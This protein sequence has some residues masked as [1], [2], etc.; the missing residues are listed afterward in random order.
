MPI[1]LTY[2]ELTETLPRIV[3]FG[4]GGAGGNAVN[5]M[6]ESE[7]QGVEFVA[8]NT[9]AQALNKSR[10]SKQ[11][12]LGAGLT[13]GLGAGAQP[14]VG[15]QAAEEA[16]P[17]LM[18]HLEGAHMCF[19]T[20]GMGGG[21]GT[22]A[23][24]VIARAA[25]EA[26]VLTVGVVTKPFQFEGK[27]RLAIAEEGVKELQRNVDTLIVIPNQNL[28]R[29]AN[30]KTTFADAFKIADEVLHS[31][32]RSITDLMVQPGLINLDFADVRTVMNEMGKAMM[33]TGQ[34]EGEERA[35]R[36][37]GDAIANP[38]LEDLSLKS[39]RGVLINVTGGMDL[40]LH[41]V[42]EAASL[43]REEVD[44]DA[45][46]IIGSILDPEL[47]GQMRV[48]VVATGIDAIE[49]EAAEPMAGFTPRVVASTGQTGRPAATAAQQAAANPPQ[50][51]PSM[52][53]MPS[54]GAGATA[55]KMEPEDHAAPDEEA[56][57]Q[58]PVVDDVAEA[59]ARPEPRAE[60]AEQHADKQNYE[61]PTFPT[62]RN[63]P[64]PARP[65]IG[66]KAP[67][68]P[69]PKPAVAAPRHAAGA[70]RD[71]APKARSLFDRLTGRA[72]K[73]EE[74]SKPEPRRGLFGARTG[75]SA[76]DEARSEPQMG[77]PRLDLGEPEQKR[78]QAVEDD[79]DIPAFLRRQAN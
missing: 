24:P 38:L 2:P 69:E 40:T 59:A 78:S 36:A 60:A 77:A 47:D 29:V 32:V 26:G 28:F 22:G 55:L 56:R 73:Q 42:D 57:V 15:R 49:E 61:F 68:E 39:A 14:D 1:N 13:Q 7:L 43:I 75:G 30:E 10:A 79:L 51:Q 62:N 27:R 35:R 11:I 58:P 76:E 44:E 6:I 50:P 17:Q 72:P 63:G 53:R 34:A 23:A 16:M 45:H 64:P 31:G 65:V 70:E 3:V 67:V 48:S 20:A 19:I 74:A 18:E 5:N 25:R 37:A 4:V 41:E 52:P 33:G 12:Q 71:D 54:F 8:A 9:D 46:I 21:T 66:S